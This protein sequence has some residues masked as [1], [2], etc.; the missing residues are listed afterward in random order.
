[1]HTNRIVFFELLITF[2]T[3]QITAAQHIC[4]SAKNIKSCT[5][6]DGFTVVSPPHIWDKCGKGNRPAKHCDC[7]I[8]GQWHLPPALCDDGSIDIAS[9]TCKDGKV[10][11]GDDVCGTENHPRSCLCKDGSNINM[12]QYAAFEEGE[13]VDVEL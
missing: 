6:A 5:C 10:V 2:I 12:M 3:L 9:C 1:M 4:G 13:N 7:K 8:G 11:V